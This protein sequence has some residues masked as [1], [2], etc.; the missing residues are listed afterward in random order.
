M[1]GKVRPCLVLTPS[2]ADNELA[3]VNVIPHTTA[4]REG[5]PWQVEIA[6]PWLKHGAFHVQQIFNVPPPKFLRLCGT[7]SREEFNLIKEKLALRL[8]LRP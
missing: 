4:L 2:P 6:K 8:G 3:L 5:N 7:L 1:V